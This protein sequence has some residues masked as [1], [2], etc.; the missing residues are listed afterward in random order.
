MQ[1]FVIENVKTKKQ[2]KSVI[3]KHFQKNE[4]TK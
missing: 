2:N 1:M 4:N 3:P